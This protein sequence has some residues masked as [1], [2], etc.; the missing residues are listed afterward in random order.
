MSKSCHSAFPTNKTCLF[1]I[2]PSHFTRCHLYSL[3]CP[4]PHRPLLSAHF[5]LATQPTCRSLPRASL[6]LLG[7]FLTKRAAGRFDSVIS[8]NRKMLVSGKLGA[9][10]IACVA[11]HA[12]P[13][14]P[15]ECPYVL[16]SE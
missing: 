2:R 8:E 13:L 14:A 9:P 1:F 5:V 16:V 4:V 15:S 10:N 3:S 6:Q 7:S 11:I 12:A